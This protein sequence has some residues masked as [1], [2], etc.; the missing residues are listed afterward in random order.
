LNAAVGSA[1]SSSLVAH[2]RKIYDQHL[3]WPIV[4]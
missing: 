2:R 4:L 3:G 1:V